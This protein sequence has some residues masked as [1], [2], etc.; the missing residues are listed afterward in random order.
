MNLKIEE[1]NIHLDNDKISIIYLENDNITPIVNGGQQNI[2]KIENKEGNA[3]GYL[4]NKWNNEFKKIDFKDK[5]IILQLI[6]ND[7]QNNITVQ[8]IDKIDFIIEVVPDKAPF[9]A[10][11]FYYYV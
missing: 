9:E 10:I 4:L 3:I 1:K 2:L 8:H 5:D 7:E 6:D 11:R